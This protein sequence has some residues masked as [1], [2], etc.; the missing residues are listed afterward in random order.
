MAAHPYDAVLQ[1]TLNPVKSDSRSYMAVR[2]PLIL[3]SATEI[4][5]LSLPVT[6]S[7][8]L[9]GFLFEYDSTDS[10]SAHDGVLILKSLDNRR[11]KRRPRAVVLPSDVTNNNATP[12]TL[13]DITALKFPVI[14]GKKCRFKF[15]IIYTAAATTTG[16]RFTIN[17]PAVTT[18]HYRSEYSL[19][20]TSRTVNDGMTTYNQ[21]A[22]ANATSAATGSNSAVVEG[23]IQP[24]ASGDVIARFA[25]EVASSAIVAKAA[26]SFVDWQELP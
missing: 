6:T 8:Y 16:A 3:A 5:T 2:V 12:D 11:Y 19:T 24:S 14:S 1:D 4:T 21:P 18:L 7:V 17:G 25:S 20:T 22:A 10:T 13:A 15:F 9:D 26:F 23:V